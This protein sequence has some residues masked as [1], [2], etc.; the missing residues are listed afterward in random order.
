MPTTDKPC[1]MVLSIRDINRLAKTARDQSKKQSGKVKPGFCL[2]IDAQ[3]GEE[4]NGLQIRSWSLAPLE[5]Y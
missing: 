5:I 3:C 1:Y 2:V 4:S